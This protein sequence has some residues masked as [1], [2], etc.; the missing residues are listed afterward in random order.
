MTENH[1]NS[2]FSCVKEEEKKARASRNYNLGLLTIGLLPVIALNTQSWYGNK[3]IITETATTI[4]SVF[5]LLLLGL[6]LVL[7]NT[8]K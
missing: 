5:I 2:K 1:G 3:D 6:I 7:A 8:R 4:I